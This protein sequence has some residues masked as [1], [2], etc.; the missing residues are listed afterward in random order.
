MSSYRYACRRLA[1][2][3]THDDVAQAITFSV[4]CRW[5]DID[6]AAVDLLFTTVGSTVAM[7]ALSQVSCT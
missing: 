2:F 6:L 1:F 5:H 3:S 4:C 7:A